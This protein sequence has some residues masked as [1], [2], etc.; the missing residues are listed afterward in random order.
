MKHASIA[1]DIPDRRG[2]TA[3]SGFGL[4]ETMMS[5]LILILLGLAIIDGMTGLQSVAALQAD[6][7]AVMESG[8]LAADAIERI[9]RQGGND[10][11][12]AG[13][14]PFSIPASGELWVRSDIT[15]AASPGD[16]NK[17]DPDGDADDSLEDI[18]IRRGQSTDRL[19]MTTGSGGLQIVAEGIAALQIDFFDA[20]GVQTV[21]ADAFSRA[22]ITL[23]QANRTG[24]FAGVLLLSDVQLAAR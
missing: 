9:V 23:R 12:L 22:R 4:T 13:F 3:Q 14:E 19:E 18:L 1:E 16:P 17:G 5:S 24:R 7:Q 2:A 21:A 11:F 8:I 10:P 15:G 20:S 6:L